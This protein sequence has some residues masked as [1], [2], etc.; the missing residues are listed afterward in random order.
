VVDFEALLT[1]YKF[2]ADMDVVAGLDS[3]PDLI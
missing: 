1:Q 3:R 2:I